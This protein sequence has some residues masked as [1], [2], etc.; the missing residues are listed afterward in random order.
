MCI[1][2]LMNG[3][4]CSYARVQGSRGSVQLQGI[5]THSQANHSQ[6]RMG[7]HDPSSRPRIADMGNISDNMKIYKNIRKFMKTNKNVIRTTTTTTTTMGW[8]QKIKGNIKKHGNVWKYIDIYGNTWFAYIHM[9]WMSG[10]VC[11]VSEPAF[12]GVC[13]CT[14]DVQTDRRM[15]GRSRGWADGRTGGRTDG[16]A[17]GRKCG[18]TAGRTDGRVQRILAHILANH[19]QARMGKHILS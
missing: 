15:D 9:L 5:L 4:L 11:W 7:K 14:L 19:S 1:A 6:T 17:D 13:N 18:R 3:C 12:R 2:V 16:Q 10:L 8:I